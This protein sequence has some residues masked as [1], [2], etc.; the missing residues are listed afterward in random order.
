[1]KISIETIRALNKRYGCA[2]EIMPNGIDELVEK[3]GAQ[4]GA[5]EEVINLG[6]KYKGIVISKVVSCE[7]HPNADKLSLC[8]IDDGGVVNR[9][10]RNKEG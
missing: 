9:V 10:D 6:P 8:M 2:D 7:K 1:M 5:V 3:I 4:L